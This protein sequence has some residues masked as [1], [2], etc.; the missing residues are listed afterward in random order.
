M[1]IKILKQQQEKLLQNIVQVLPQY[2]SIF[3]F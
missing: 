3:L 2:C 1:F